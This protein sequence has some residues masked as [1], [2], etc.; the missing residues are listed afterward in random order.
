METP[1]RVAHIPGEMS[2][3]GVGTVVLNYFRNIDRR[4]IQFDFIVIEGSTL[5]CRDEIESLGGR[6][7][8]IPT[9]NKFASFSKELK[10]VFNENNYNIVHSHLTALNVISLCI[11]KMCGVK[12]RIAHSHNTAGKG[13]FARNIVKYVLRPFSRTFS[14]DYYACTEHAGNW[15]F[16]E[17]IF[18][19][20]GIIINNAI[21]IDKFKYDINTRK[22]LRKEFC[23]ENKFVIGHVGR[24]M[25]QKN[26]GFILDIFYEMQK[27]R[28]DAI[29]ILIGDEY[30]SMFEEVKCKL[31][32]LKLE[33][34]VIILP[35]RN[36]VNKIYQIFDLF[37]FPSLYE[38]FGMALIE[39][40][41]AGLPCV[42]SDAVPIDAKICDLVTFLSLKKTADYW[43]KECLKLSNVQRKSHVDEAKESGFDIVKEAKKLEE[44]YKLLIQQSDGRP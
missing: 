38:G 10:K 31:R 34:K 37:L 17:K 25:K 33:K 35:P 1:I 41:V 20:K 18:K 39:A 43:A 30:G 7:I 14:T 3:G 5:P 29:L 26:Q 11:A 9:Y 6:I 16:G 22:E 4:L 32:D 42:A 28:E 44:R 15:L 2:S 24:F 12:I 8:I 23:I 27:M 21:D 40:Q 36:D 13:E 19:E